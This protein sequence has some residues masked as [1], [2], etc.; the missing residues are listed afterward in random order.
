M[1]FNDQA[2][3]LYNDKFLFTEVSSTQLDQIPHFQDYRAVMEVYGKDFTGYAKMTVVANM[4][5]KQRKKPN[6]IGP[7]ADLLEFFGYKMENH[8][9]EGMGA[10]I[11]YELP[12]TERYVEIYAVYDENGNIAVSG[13]KLGK[14]DKIFYV[15]TDNSN[16]TMR[17]QYSLRDWPMFL[18]KPVEAS[19]LPEGPGRYRWK[20]KLINNSP[21]DH[22]VYGEHIMNGSQVINMGAPMGEAAIDRGSVD[23]NIGKS[24]V[25]YIVGRTRMGFSRTVTDV[26]WQQGTFMVGRLLEEKMDSDSLELVSDLAMPDKVA[27]QE[28]DVKFAMGAMEQMDNYLTVGLS[29]TPGKH[30]VLD[31]STD[32]QVELGPTLADSIRATS[33]DQYSTRYFSLNPILSK[34]KRR[35]QNIENIDDRNSIVFDLWTGDGGWGLIQKDLIEN[36]DYNGFVDSDYHVSDGN[37]KGVDPR[38]KQIN[39]N[40]LIRTGIYLDTHGL[41]RANHDSKI[42]NKGFMTGTREYNGLR[43]SSYWMLVFSSLQNDQQENTAAALYTCPSLEQF[44]YQIAG[45]GPKG[46]PM[47]V[48]YPSGGAYNYGQLQGNTYGVV[49]DHCKTLFVD[50]HGVQLWLPDFK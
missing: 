1:L 21:T 7:K 29:P 24:A 47:K 41:F 4:A 30:A 40:R 11:V 42:L 22:M 38:R 37:S 10:E 9:F 6:F 34:C 50:F 32:Y 12:Q 2:L 43:M 16:W 18:F 23:I 5:A 35:V 25:S 46:S 48:A 17:N 39:L 33:S 15:V 45:W 36:F 8:T 49:S 27:F 44:G 31:P 13:D 26:A 20:V 19:Y 14:Y 3:G 28:I